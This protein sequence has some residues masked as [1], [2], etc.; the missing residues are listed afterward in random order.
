[1]S[2]MQNEKVIKDILDQ[3]SCKFYVDAK[4]LINEYFDHELT[5]APFYLNS[6][7]MLYLFFYI[8][9]KYCIRFNEKDVL[10]YN[11][12]SLNKISSATYALIDNQ[13]K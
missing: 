8:E 4:Y 7:Q 6:F 11:F 13:N 12:N 1:M 3:L 10:N 2:K 9:R 5:G